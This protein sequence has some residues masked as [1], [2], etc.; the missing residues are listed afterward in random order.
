[1]IYMPACN[2]SSGTLVS[3]LKK[4]KKITPFFKMSYAFRIEAVLKHV[5][6][7]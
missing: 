1:M 4:K 3:Q 6:E 5:W 2:I 7:N